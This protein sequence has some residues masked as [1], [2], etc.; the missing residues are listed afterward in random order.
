VD[1]ARIDRTCAP[2][3]DFYRFANGAWI[4]K[5]AIPSSDTWY[6]AWPMVRDRNELVLREIFEENAKAARRA[7][8]VPNTNAGRVGAF[9]ASCTDSAAVDAAGV[10]PLQPTLD[11]IAAISSVDDLV[12]AFPSGLVLR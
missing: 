7:S 2:C 9:Y 8:T 3:K 5:T 11:T 10:K 6:G 12:R 4:K 1:T